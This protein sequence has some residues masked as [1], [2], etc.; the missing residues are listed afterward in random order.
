MAPCLARVAPHDG[1]VPAA[2]GREGTQHPDIITVYSGQGSQFDNVHVR[3]ERFK[4]KRNLLYTACT[5]A[6]K[7]LKISGI[8]VSDGGLDLRE[9]MELQPKS[10]LWQVRLGVS[11]FSSDRV[12]AARLAVR[13]ACQRAGWQ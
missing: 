1:G 6:I 3:A 8:D 2:G 5:R 11:S 7:K 10:V 13:K 12:E 4:G 9:K